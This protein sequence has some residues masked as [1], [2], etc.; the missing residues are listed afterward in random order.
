MSELSQADLVPISGKLGQ[1]I[2][3]DPGAGIAPRLEFFI[4]VVLQPVDVDGEEMKPLFRAN[5][6]LVA[7][8]RSWKGLENTAPEFPWAPKPGSVDAAVLMFGVHNPADVTALNF[9]AVA[10]GKIAVNFSSEADFEVEADRDDLEQAELSF[11]LTLAIEPLR[12]ATSLEKRLQGDEQALCGAVAEW[13]DL[14][15]YGALEK[16]PGGFAFPIGC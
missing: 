4:E 16:V 7:G 1:L 11:D 12:I 8:V 14:A 2:F 15:D 5:N 9:G 3:E 6:I 10:D 13:V